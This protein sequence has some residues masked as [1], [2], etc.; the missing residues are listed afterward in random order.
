VEVRDLPPKPDRSA[1]A[2][3]LLAERGHDV[4]IGRAR[5]AAGRADSRSGF[6]PTRC[7]TSRGGLSV[8]S[9]RSPACG[10]PDG[11]P[12][13]FEQRA[14]GAAASCRQR[15]PPLLSGT[16]KTPLGREACSPRRVRR[17]EVGLRDRSQAHPPFSTTPTPRARPRWRR[18]RP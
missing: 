4:G 13:V 6:R 14:G 11:E 12:G 1:G 3:V 18:R 15:E 5:V 16:W 7:S 17:R 8:S 2:L 10:S 9:Q